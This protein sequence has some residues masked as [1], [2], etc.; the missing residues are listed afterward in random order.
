MMSHFM[1]RTITEEDPKED[2]PLDKQIIIGVE[3]TTLKINPEMD[4]GETQMIA[5]T[6]TEMKVKIEAEKGMTIGE[7]KVVET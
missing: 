3:T 1:E 6:V 5:D 2:N 4:I 7:E